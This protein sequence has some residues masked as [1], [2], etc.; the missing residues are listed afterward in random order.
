MSRNITNLNRLRDDLGNSVEKASA[1][2]DMLYQ[3]AIN[4]DEINELSIE[5]SSLLA[6][7]VQEELECLKAKF[8]MYVEEVNNGKN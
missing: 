4:K 7:S 5:G 8:S 3:F 6:Q 1:V 2:I